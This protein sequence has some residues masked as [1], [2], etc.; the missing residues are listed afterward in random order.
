MM[1]GFPGGSVVKHLP[2]KQGTWVRAH[3]RKIPHASEQVSLCAT[4]V[5]PMSRAQELQLVSPRAPSTEACAARAH[6]SHQ[7]KPLQWEAHTLHLFRE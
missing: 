3:S 7:Q 2:T 6:A 1:E 4:A 5:E